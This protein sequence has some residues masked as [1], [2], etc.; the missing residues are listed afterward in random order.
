MSIVA[1]S[2]ALRAPAAL[3][4]VCGAYYLA[5]LIYAGLGGDI[6][7]VSAAGFLLTAAL[8]WVGIGAA[9]GRLWVPLV[10]LVPYL[11]WKLSAALTGTAI[12]SA[13]MP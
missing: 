8:L 4:A 9:F 13:G 11:G 6:E 2:D 1:K 12:R 7:A 3:I 10:P 5:F